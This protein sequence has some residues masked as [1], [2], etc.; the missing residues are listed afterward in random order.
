MCG[1]KRDKSP[2]EGNKSIIEDESNYEDYNG[3]LLINLV[4]EVVIRNTLAQAE[5][6]Q[7]QEISQQEN[8]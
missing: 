1:M 8:H 6:T 4:T 2:Y 5:A 7:D 3:I